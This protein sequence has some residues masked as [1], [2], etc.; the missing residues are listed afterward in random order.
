MQETLLDAKKREERGKGPAGRLR[1]DGLVP[2]VLYGPDIEGGISLT[3]DAMKLE[4]TLHAIGGSK[5]LVNLSVEGE[6]DKRTVI[7]KMVRRDPLKGSVTHVDLY[8]VKTGHEMILKVPLH[9]VGKAQGVSQGGILDVELREL[10]VACLPRHIPQYLEV[11]VTPL[12]LGESLHVKDITPP[13]GVRFIG[14]PNQT[15]VSIVAPAGLA[16]E[17]TEAEETESAGVEG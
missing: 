11:D 12:A 14:D 10:K 17:K 8:Q 9:I 16:A 6:A 4:K 5:V 7:F 1:R 13:E 15:V 3:V 2:A